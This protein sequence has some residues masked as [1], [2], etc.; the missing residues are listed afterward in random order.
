MKAKTLKSI[1]VGH[2]CFFFKASTNESFS[3]FPH[4]DGKNM[5]VDKWSDQGFK[6]RENIAIDHDFWSDVELLGET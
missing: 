1:V 2:E 3:A 5:V 6:S 4:W